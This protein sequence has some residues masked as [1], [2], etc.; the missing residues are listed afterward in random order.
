MSLLKAQIIHQGGQII[1]KSP[2]GERLFDVVA[3]LAV[4]TQIRRDNPII[5]R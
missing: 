3:R 5:L 1:G 4:V 2:D